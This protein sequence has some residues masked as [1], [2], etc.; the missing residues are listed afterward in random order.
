MALAPAASA[1]RESP[2]VSRLPAVDKVVRDYAPDRPSQGAACAILAD[3]LRSL[4]KETNL[5][6]GSGAEPKRFRDYE[7]CRVQAI[8]DARA[9][10]SAV[11]TVSRRLE[12]KARDPDFQREVARRYLSSADYEIWESGQKIQ[13]QLAD[14]I[15]ANT[16]YFNLIMLV[17]YLLVFAAGALLVLRALRPWRYDSQSGLLRFGARSFTFYRQGGVVVQAAASHSTHHVPGSQTIATNQY[18]HSHVVSSTAGYSYTTLHETIHLVDSAGRE[19]V[20]RLDD[21]SISARGGHLIGAMHAIRNRRRTGPYLRVWNFTLDEATS[22]RAAIK[23]MFGLGFLGWAG[24][25]LSIGNVGLLLAGI[26]ATL[27]VREGMGVMAAIPILF[28][29]PFAMIAA[30]V[31]HLRVRKR[32][33]ERFE[34]EISAP[35]RAS[36]QSEARAA[37]DRT[38]GPISRAD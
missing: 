4:S 22:N 26:F 19:Q 10:G 33:T 5:R 3:A 20:L 28:S 1:K 23:R 21:W 29:F 32:R 38:S 7:K 34:H 12:E 15:D 35:L 37:A 8:N 36:A 14:E 30:T 27:P 16:R 9:E 2:L 6:L 24:L 18:G 25:T 31:V 17:P 13:W 11:G